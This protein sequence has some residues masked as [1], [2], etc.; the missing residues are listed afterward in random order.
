MHLKSMR[1]IQRRFSNIRDKNIN[2][3]DYIV[4]ARAVK[5]QGFSKDMI[6]RWFNKLVEKDD[7]DKKDKKALIQ[8][9]VNLSKTSEE[10]RI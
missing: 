9:L 1:S 3:G 6:S 7:Y 10:H 8:H 2:L 4:F 5:G